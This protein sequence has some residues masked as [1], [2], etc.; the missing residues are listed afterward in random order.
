[1]RLYLALG[2]SITAG[3][4]VR[5]DLSFP[6]V[7]TG[8]LSNLDPDLYLINLGVNGLTTENFLTLLLM[9]ANVR[10]YVSQASLI[11]VTIGSNDLLRV[12]RGMNQPLNLSGIPII[13]GNMNKNLIRIGEEIRRL[14]PN[15]TVKA[16]TLYNPLPITLH[17]QSFRLIQ[18]VINDANAM[19]VR[20]AKYY[21][22]YTVNIDRQFRG[23]EQLLIGPDHLH[24]N[25]LGYQVIAQAFAHSRGSLFNV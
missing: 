14:N 4:G 18:G 16:A 6:A 17:S 23:K 19:I 21:N 1:M 11:T 9:R 10:H 8:Y 7:Y 15:A 5:S 25:A 2:D 24:P 20:W 13:L 12:V 22:F 3:Y